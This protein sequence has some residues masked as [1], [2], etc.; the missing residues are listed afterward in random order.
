M[1]CSLLYLCGDW[2]NNL[3]GSDRHDQVDYFEGRPVYPGIDPGLNQLPHH[4]LKYFP[5]S[6][7]LLEI[8]L[9]VVLAKFKR[10]VSIKAK[11]HF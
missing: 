6:P 2:E 11:D 4:E 5:I 10:L 8:Y 1:I 9:L 7:T 3:L